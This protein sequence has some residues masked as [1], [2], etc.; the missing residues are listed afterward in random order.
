[1]EKISS[2]SVVRNIPLNKITKNQ[3]QPRNYFNEDAIIE[4][5]Q[6]MKKHGLLQPIIIRQIDGTDY[7]EIVAGERRFRA[8]QTLEW[9]YIPAIVR[10]YTDQQSMQLAL[11]ENIQREDL[12]PIEEALAIK[13][14]VEQY[15]FSHESVARL[16]G[17]SRAFVS[18]ILRLLNLPELVRQYLIDG[19][20]S[21]G[22]ARPLLA[23]NDVQLQIDMA[24]QIV[25]QMWSAREVEKAVRQKSK[26]DVQTIDGDNSLHI[27]AIEEELIQALG[28]KITI[29][30]N[31]DKG[32]IEIEYYSLDD[33]E[34]L[35]SILKS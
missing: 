8:A 17:K 10:E 12:N 9:Q 23:L 29:T 1:M 34:R 22:Q 35:I 27:L 6:S 33:L 14:L 25:T 13:A 24:K 15:D 4:L 2:P 26:K 18:N 32:K 5:A 3:F 16:I 21:V 30:G 31:A 28:N 19:R 11:I 7:F 20:L